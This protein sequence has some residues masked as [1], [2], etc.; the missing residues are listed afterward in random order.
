MA[1]YG[2]GLLN[3]DKATF[4]VLDI[5]TLQAVAQF[6]QMLNEQHGTE[7]YVIDPEMDAFVDTETLYY[8]L[9]A[10]IDLY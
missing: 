8:L 6:Q 9:Y 3:E 2:F 5:G 1:L 7:I 4:G 10:G